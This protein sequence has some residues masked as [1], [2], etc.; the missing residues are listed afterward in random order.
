MRQVMLSTV[1]NPFDPFTEFS[2]WDTW[3]RQAGYC[4]TAFLA[5]VV[6]TSEE[7]SEGDQM[8][9]VER[10]IDEIVKYDELEVYIKLERD[11]SVIVR[12]SELI[13]DF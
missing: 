6:T 9:A 12:P 7:L 11:V 8:L 2:S 4:C 5:R 10:G 13:T 3:D 1:D